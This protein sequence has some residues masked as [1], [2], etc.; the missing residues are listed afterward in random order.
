MAGLYGDRR[1]GTSIPAR[2]FG[3][4]TAELVLAI[5]LPALF[6]ATAQ[7]CS[8]LGKSAWVVLTVLHPA[9]QLANWQATCPYLSEG[10][11]F[12][13]ILLEVGVC[14]RT[15]LCALAGPA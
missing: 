11:R 9:I 7:W 5:S 12:A 3:R 10:P 4:V 15:V 13:Q 8:M 2:T 1:N 14:I 6:G